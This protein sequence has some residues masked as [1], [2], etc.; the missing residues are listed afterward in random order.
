MALVNLKLVMREIGTA[1]DTIPG[2]AVHNRPVLN[3]TPPAAVVSYPDSIETRTTYGP[4]VARMVLPVVVMV[5]RPTE[6]STQDRVTRYADGS[7]PESV[8]RIMD[9]YAW[10]T[11]HHVTVTGI[12]F[13]VVSMAGKDHLAVAFTLDVVGSAA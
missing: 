2:L 10:T 1:L 13:D 4:G 3:L 9:T 7:G 12:D 11:C 5:G 6:S 8:T